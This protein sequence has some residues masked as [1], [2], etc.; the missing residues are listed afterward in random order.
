[1][2]SPLNSLTIK[3]ACIAAHVEELL[4]PNGHEAD[5]EAIKGLLADPEVRAWL[6]DPKNAIFLPLKR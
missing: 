4:S 6:D 5:R 3:L 1:M 2:T